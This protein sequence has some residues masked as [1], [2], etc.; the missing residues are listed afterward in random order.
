MDEKAAAQ[1]A[2]LDPYVIKNFKP[3]Q[4]FN[5]KSDVNS[6]DY[7]D[8]GQ[9]LVAASDDDS[10]CLFSCQTGEKKKTVIC[11]RY[12]TAS[13]RF[14]HHSKAILCASKYKTITDSVRYWSLHDNKVLRVFPGHRESVVQISMH[15]SN[16]TFMTGS[17]DGVVKFWDLR[18]PKPSAMLEGEGVPALSYD[19]QGLI[20]AIAVSSDCISLYDSRKY[21]K[22]PFS[23]FSVSS[24]GQKCSISHIKFTPD[25]DHVLVSRS[26]GS[27]YMLDSFKGN[28]VHVY[29]LR[30]QPSTSMM[31]RIGSKTRSFEPS[32]SPDG[33]YMLCG[34]MQ[35]MHAVNCGDG[36]LISTWTTHMSPPTVTSWNPRKLMFA[37]ADSQLILWTPPQLKEENR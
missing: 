11:K 9:F 5:F 33:N 19:P 14:T 28:I 26:N 34:S 4:K 6:L 31:K 18:D 2:F 27:H 24:E 13:V 23:T 20:M 12:G 7:S 36:K 35:G 22:G 3:A 8:D 25:G 29:P 30:F 32:I 15:P 1:K 37:S 16:D 17:T 10:V 21:D